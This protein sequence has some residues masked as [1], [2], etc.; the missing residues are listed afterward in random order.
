MKVQLAS[1]LAE[2]DRELALRRNVYRKRVHSGKMHRHQAEQ[3]YLLLKA[4]RRALLLSA[5]QEIPMPDEKEIL[6]EL[7]SA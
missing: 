5:P 2:I 1:I 7:Y 3:Q 6:D 4:A